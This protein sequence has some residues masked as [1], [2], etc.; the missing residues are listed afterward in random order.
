MSLGQTPDHSRYFVPHFL[1][2]DIRVFVQNELHDHQRNAYSCC[3]IDR[4]LAQDTNCPFSGL[5]AMFDAGGS[6]VHC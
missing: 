6:T 1:R 3:H 5:P 2:G 4:K